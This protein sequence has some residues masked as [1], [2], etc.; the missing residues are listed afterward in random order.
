MFRVFAD[1]HYGPFSLDDLAFFADLLYGWF[2]FHLITI[3]FRLF[4]SPGYAALRQIVYRYF[5]GDLVAREDPYIVH[6]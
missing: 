1:N 4:S 6:S 3:P 2:N 5:D